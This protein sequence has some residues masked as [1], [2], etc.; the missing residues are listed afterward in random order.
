[1]G[2]SIA[3]GPVDGHLRRSYHGGMVAPAPLVDAYAVRPFEE[4]AHGGAVVAALRER[5]AEAVGGL[6]RPEGPAGPSP[7]PSRT[8]PDL[9]LDLP[10]SARRRCLER[11]LL[12]SRE[13]PLGRRVD[14]WA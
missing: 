13:D 14:L 10:P 7:V 11:Y 8:L 1:M 3:G 6:V 5:V 9:Y 4:T 2:S 12:I